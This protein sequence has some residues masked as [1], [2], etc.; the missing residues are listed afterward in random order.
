[1]RRLAQVD[2]LV[3]H[4]ELHEPQRLPRSR[5][6]MSAGR[7]P[8]AGPA[9]PHAAESIPAREPSTT[10]EY[11][12]GPRVLGP[13]QHEAASDQSGRHRACSRW[14]QSRKPTPGDTPL[15][16]ATY[17]CEVLHSS[18]VVLTEPTEG[19][20]VGSGSLFRCAVRTSLH[21]C[22]KRSSRRLA[23]R[24]RLGMPLMDGRTGRRGLPY[25]SM[26][27][28]RPGARVRR[29]LLHTFCTGS[30]W[31]SRIR[32]FTRSS[33]AIRRGSSHGLCRSGG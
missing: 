22:G 31:V 25:C 3:R 15:R 11:L 30:S 18:P 9:S 28:S 2:Q 1:M 33:N 21:A 26:L 14:A 20:F 4:D 10:D 29:S 19:G 6:R 24:N 32:A 8:P 17:P 13:G 12:F 7:R 27:L 23:V 16:S 5:M